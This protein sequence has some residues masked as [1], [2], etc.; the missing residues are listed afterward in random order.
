MK[1]FVTPIIDVKKY[2]GKQVAIV[3]GKIVASG[4]TAQEVLEKAQR[5][6][7]KATWRDVLIVSVPEGI[8]VVYRL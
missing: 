3:K 2:G 8:T 4:D 7:P 6:F 1:E 5:K